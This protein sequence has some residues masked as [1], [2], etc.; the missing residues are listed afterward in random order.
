MKHYVLGNDHAQL[1]RT[2][3]E[4]QRNIDVFLNE[5]ESKASAEMV[6]EFFQALNDLVEDHT[7]SVN[8]RCAAK[9]P[10]GDPLYWS[11]RTAIFWGDFHKTWLNDYN[12]TSRLSQVL[13]LAPRSIL[14]GGAVLL[15]AQTGRGDQT[16]AAIHPNFLAAAQEIG[17]ADCHQCS[18]RSPDGRVHS[19]ATKLSALR[20]LS[21]FVA[22]DHGEHLAET[23]RS[24]IGLTEP[25]RSCSSQLATRLIQRSGA[26]PMVRQVVE[27]MLKNVEDPLKI[28]DL[29]EA[30]GAST[31]QLQRRF[32]NKTG[33]KLL[34]TY[35]ELRLE[36]AYS[37]LRYTDMPQLEISAATGFSSA[38][39][40]GRA[41]RAQYKTTPEAVRSHRFAGNLSEL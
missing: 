26:D 31:R 12:D 7:Y 36:R 23:L 29:A 10:A 22:L 41:F 40:L 2:T 28:S 4:R 37:L 27:K 38:G 15:L 5:S 19:A 33:V 35:R 30:L 17:L 8:I 13:N 25:K 39:A 3:I 6:V 11:G 14:V 16:V 9:A 32:L 21:E 34:T 18:H 24:Y 20:L 1:A